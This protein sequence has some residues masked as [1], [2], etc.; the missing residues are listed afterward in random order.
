MATGAVGASPQQPQHLLSPPGATPMAWSPAAIT[1]PIP[2]TG[3]AST[4][5]TARPPTARLPPPLRPLP[6]LPPPRP[7]PL[8]HP[9][10]LPL[11][12]EATPACARTH[13]DRVLPPTPSPLHH[14]LP[15]LM[16]LAL[17]S[18]LLP[19]LSPPSLPPWPPPLQP[20][21]RQSHPRYLRQ[22]WPH[23][24]NGRHPLSPP[25]SPR[26]P[27]S[28]AHPP[29]PRLPLSVQPPL[30]ATG[31][32]LPLWQGATKPPRPPPLP[33][34]PCQGAWLLQP[35]HPP[36]CPS[37]LLRSSRSRRRSTSP[38]RAPCHLLAAPRRP[39]R[40]W[41]CQ[42]TPA[43][44][45]GEGRLVSP[46]DGEGCMGHGRGNNP[47]PEVQLCPFAFFVMLFT[48]PQRLSHSICPRPHPRS[49]ALSALMGFAS[50]PQIQQTPGP[51]LQLL[52]PH[53]P[54]LCAA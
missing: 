54:V 33:H 50:H 45:P 3:C 46:K 53:R 40:W 30:L 25:S 11:P 27:T 6:P 8:P 49:P 28:Q 31:W 7:L 51:W 29:L 9:L 17:Q 34:H 47:K 43:S 41:M 5:H 22:L 32:P 38:Q 10:L 39:P 18:P 42:A 2:P 1:L 14:P 44:P 19:P 13:R 48:F 20:P 35:R 15:L 36:H 52:L 23:M 26:P 4:L 12:R 24:G 37:A 21:T 16:G